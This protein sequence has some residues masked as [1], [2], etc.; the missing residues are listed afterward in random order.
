MLEDLR[1]S[2][3][4]A[5]LHG[6]GGLKRPSHFHVTQKKS[7][8]RRLA[9]C[10]ILAL[11]TAGLLECSLRWIFPVSFF[12]APESDAFFIAKFLETELPAVLDRN[13]EWDPRLGWRVTRS[14][15][16]DGESSNSRGLRGAKEYSYERTKGL[17]RGV[18]IGD[19][20][21]YGLAVADDEAYPAQI[22]SNLKNC[23]ILNFGVNGYGFDQQ[24]LSWLGEGIKYRPDF[25][26]VGFF[27]DDFHRNAN[28]FRVLPK[29]QFRLIGDKLELIERQL[30]SPDYLK[31]HPA[32]LR[33]AVARQTGW[34]R[35]GLA[36]SYFWYRL[37]RKLN[38]WREADSS[39]DEKSRLTDAL[40][41]R[42]RE[43]CQSVGAALVVCSIPH[44]NPGFPDGHRIQD[45][46]EAS[47]QE[48]GI[49]HL[50]LSRTL[51]LAKEM[52]DQVIS[53]LELH[54]S[55]MGNRFAAEQ[56]VQF[57]RSLDI[58]K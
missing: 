27:V 47:C 17:G 14:L 53:P 49:P 40:L 3:Y 36:T 13:I 38:G 25:V 51:G 57:L 15:R 55:A 9:Q 32:P 2:T 50:R 46:I 19:S 56:M 58:V 29:P 52:A 22:E 42:L 4:A 1:A 21:T 20:F 18:V 48:M 41:Q 35:V 12:V 24:V 26:L 39:F 44:S 54:W 23:E 33:E 45:S 30:H 6:T 34:S 43:S 16:R 5:A 10:V 31:Q 37:N 7:L 11:I 8:K 28:G